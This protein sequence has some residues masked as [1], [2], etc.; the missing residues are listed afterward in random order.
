MSY[1]ISVALCTYNGEKFIEKQLESVLSQTYPVNEIIICDDGSNDSTEEIIERVSL[2]HK[3]IITF[4]KN[5]INLKSV[6]NLCKNI[7]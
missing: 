6:K 5:E 2:K 1:K 4:Y 3:G 7:I